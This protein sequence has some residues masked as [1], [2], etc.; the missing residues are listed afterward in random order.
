MLATAFDVG[1]RDPGA[2]ERLSGDE[3]AALV[4]QQFAANPPIPPPAQAI[5]TSATAPAAAKGAAASDDM[6]VDVA[7]P[8]VPSAPSF[9]PQEEDEPKEDRGLDGSD[10]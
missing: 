4:Q 1:R 2:W 8:E 9:R 5:G 3:R 7:A 10:P 6:E